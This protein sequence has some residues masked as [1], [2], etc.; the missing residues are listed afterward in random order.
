MNVNIQ[1]YLQDAFFGAVG[2]LVE[3]VGDLPGVLGFEVSYEL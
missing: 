3:T 2:K 1:T